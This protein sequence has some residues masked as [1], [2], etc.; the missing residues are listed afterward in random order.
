[1]VLT[2]LHCHVPRPATGS[3]QQ[4]QRVMKKVAA[5]WQRFMQDGTDLERR[6]ARLEVATLH[7]PAWCARCA[8][9]SGG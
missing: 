8:A 2:V 5:M 4:R 6:Y 7:D 1:M 3:E 9:E